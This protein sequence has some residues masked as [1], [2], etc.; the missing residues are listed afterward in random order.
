MIHFH[1][2]IQCVY[3]VCDIP[4]SLLFFIM[5]QIDSTYMYE[6]VLGIM[7][8]NIIIV[9]VVVLKTLICVLIIIHTIQLTTTML[10]IFKHH[11]YCNNIRI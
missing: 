11:N 1:F 2:L 8:N 6:T 3:F 9:I 10:S 5:F 4:T 7:K